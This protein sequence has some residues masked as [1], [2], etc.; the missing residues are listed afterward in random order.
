M[1]DL[2]D[3]DTGLML[4]ARQPVNPTDRAVREIAPLTEQVVEE[5]INTLNTTT[6]NTESSFHWRNRAEFTIVPLSPYGAFERLEGVEFPGQGDNPVTFRVGPASKEVVAYLLCYIGQHPEITKQPRWTVTR[7]RIRRILLDNGDTDRDD[8]I[9]GVA[10]EAL[11]FTALHVRSEKP[12]SDFDVLANSFLFHVAYNMDVAARIGMDPLLEL[13]RIDRVRRASA[14]SLDAP[15]QTYT[16]DLVHHYMM[17]VAAEVP[18]LEYLSYYHIAEHYFEKV[19]NDDL[20]EQVRRGITDP[21]F[22]VRRARDVQAII[23]I[24]RKSQRQVKEEGGV[25]EQRALQ[26]VL[27]RF[28]DITRLLNDLITYD[29]TLIDYYKAN[30]VA[31]AG[32]G[33]VDLANADE[34]AIR[35]ALAKRIYKVRNALVHAKDGELPKYAPFGH[36]TELSREVPLMRFVAEQIIILHGKAL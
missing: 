15:R 17:G 12:R 30:E 26:L 10:K 29:S 19:F 18:L 16:P 35:S 33:K 1:R 6:S 9:L 5:I 27:E 21:S 4:R 36:D 7:M 14:R 3:T 25:N 2:E 20:V 13:R 24:V 8:T 34:D 11:S 31:F 22:S 32:A 28:V 23:S